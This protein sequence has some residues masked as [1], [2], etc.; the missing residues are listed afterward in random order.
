MFGG[1]V[2]GCGHFP[3]CLDRYTASA[4]HLQ[5]EGLA[6]PSNQRT[7]S[8]KPRS[9]TCAV[10]E[11]VPFGKVACACQRKAISSNLATNHYS[12][13]CVGPIAVATR[14]SFC[15][16]V[17]KSTRWVG[18]Q[19]STAA[20]VYWHFLM[21]TDIPGRQG[22]CL[23]CSPLFLPRFLYLYRFLTTQYV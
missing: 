7:F 21:S 3:D 2:L 14:S 9:P 4:D 5:R 20:L 16:T 6:Q 11:S 18:T 1:C 23:R 22:G 10:S 19:E 17:F 12:L 8:E 15:P 13:H